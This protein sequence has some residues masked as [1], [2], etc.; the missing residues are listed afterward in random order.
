M[1]PREQYGDVAWLSSVVF[2]LHLSTWPPQAST[3]S[4]LGGILYLSETPQE[5]CGSENITRGSI[6]IVVS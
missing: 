5:L 6:V 2:F 4:A 1:T 3:V